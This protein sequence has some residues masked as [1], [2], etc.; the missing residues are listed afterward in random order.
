MLHLPHRDGIFCNCCLAIILWLLYLSGRHCINRR[1]NRL[2]WNGP[3]KW[4]TNVASNISLWNVIGSARIY[5]IQRLLVIA[6][7]ETNYRANFGTHQ[8]ENWISQETVRLML[9]L[10]PYCERKYSVI[11]PLFS[12]STCCWTQTL[13]WN[14][15]CILFQSGQLNEY[16]ERK[17]MSSDVQCMA[18]GTVPAG[19]QR[20]RFLAI[21]LSDNTVRV[22]SLDPQDCLQ[23]LSMQ[24]LPAT[25]ESL[26]IV[27]MAM[28]GLESESG[29][30]GGLFLNI[31]LSVCCFV[32]FLSGGR[33]SKCAVV[34]LMWCVLSCRMACFLEQF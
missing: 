20:S 22:I 31:G 10:H 18:L 34:L 5:E 15:S 27:E 2:F 7:D 1:R 21:G 30:L 11:C 33:W 13:I 28:G 8:K 14:L 4:S 24:A 32:V 9:S 3:G 17:E 16:T 23:P 19:E 12:F 25:P 29:R 26:C 6:C